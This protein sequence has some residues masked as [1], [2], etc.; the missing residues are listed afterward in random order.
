MAGA[1]G[2]E[3]DEADVEDGVAVGA[4]LVRRRFVLDRRRHGR[5]VG[6]GGSL[7]HRHRRQLRLGERPLAKLHLKLLHVE[8][9]LRGS[10]IGM[11]A[12]MYVDMDVS[13]TLAAGLIV[14]GRMRGGLSK[15]A[16]RFA[17]VPS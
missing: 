4:V 14:R 10:I 9:H 5:D 17:V 7:G 16:V 3:G 2:G 11:Y 13:I 15:Q 1:H 8:W 6:A 12:C